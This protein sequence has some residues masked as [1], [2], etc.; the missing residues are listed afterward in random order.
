MSRGAGCLGLRCGHGGGFNMNFRRLVGA[1]VVSV[2]LGIGCGGSDSGE[3]TGQG[4][5]SSD[6][7]VD[8]GGRGGASGAGTSTAGRA[9]AIGSG[10]GGN[11]GVNTGS[12][13]AQDA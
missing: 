9:G 5:A 10:T 7:S 12:G 8:S 1:G 4:G 3:L 13:G 6:A 11:G 2:L